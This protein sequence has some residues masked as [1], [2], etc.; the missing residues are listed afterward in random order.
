MTT[1]R[2]RYTSLQIWLLICAAMVFCMAVIGAIT[3]LTES[4]LSM[5]EWRPLIGVLPPLREQEWERVFGLYQQSPEFTHKHHW[6]TLAEFKNIFFWEWFHRLWGR[7]IGLVF[8]VPFIVFLVRKMIPRGYAL[9]LWGLFFLGGLQGVVGWWMVKSG[10]I[11][12][13]DVDHFRLAV[14]LSMALLIYGLLLWTVFDLRADESAAEHGRGARPL[15]G[16]LCLGLLAVTVVWGAFVAGLDAG[17]VYNSFPL[18]NGALFPDEAF[19]ASA[20][21]H[22]HG[23]IQFVHRWLAKLTAVAVLVFAYQHKAYW[24]GAMVCVQVALGV[25][26][27][28]TVLWIPAAALHQAGA[29]LLIGLLLHALHR[30]AYHRIS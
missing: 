29:L 21:I 3:R 26:A 4:G 16:W 25:A 10:L 8:A 30:T 7:L 15:F 23:W 24:L 6:M 22:D 13:P 14:H 18:M 1:E 20:V 9:R 12:R 11:D 19:H 27:L 28:L 5:V 2:P 17:R